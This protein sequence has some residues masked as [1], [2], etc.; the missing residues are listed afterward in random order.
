M[1]VVTSDYIEFQPTVNENT[2]KL[3]VKNYDKLQELVDSFIKNNSIFEEI[4]DEANLSACKEER[5]KLN[6]AIKGVSDIRKKVCK[7]YVGDF[8]A[9]CKAI[10]KALQQKADLHTQSINKFKTEEDEKVYTIT[11][12]TKDQVTVDKVY[13]YAKRL[14]CKIR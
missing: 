2:G 14:G 12:T 1:E 3:E 4:T 9:Q 6:R 10:E 11:I 8:E 7:F 5:T 13:N